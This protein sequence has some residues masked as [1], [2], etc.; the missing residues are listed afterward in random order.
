[1]EQIEHVDVLDLEYASEPEFTEYQE[2]DKKSELPGEVTIPKK[3]IKN[4]LRKLIRKSKLNAKYPEHVV[5]IQQV[6]HQNI[7]RIS[8]VY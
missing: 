6:K 2:L 8:G 4:Q 3:S 5:S 1:M 7:Y